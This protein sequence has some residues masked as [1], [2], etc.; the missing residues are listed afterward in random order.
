[1]KKHQKNLLN[2]LNRFV[3]KSQIHIRKIKTKSRYIRFEKCTANIAFCSFKELCA[4]NLAHEDYHNI[5]KA[6]LN[7]F[8]F[9]IFPYLKIIF[10]I[11]VEDLLV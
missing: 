1:M 2:Y 11:N 6:L 3:D 5:A 8:L 7:Y 10:Q 4:T 9:L